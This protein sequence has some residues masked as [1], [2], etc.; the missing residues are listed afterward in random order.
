MLSSLGLSDGLT[1]ICS[2]FLKNFGG[3]V[4]L[5]WCAGSL[6]VEQGLSC[7]TARG[8]LVPQPG[9]GPT[10]LALEGEFFFLISIGYFIFAKIGP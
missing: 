2:S 7:P 10:S 1:L 6:V 3:T 5:L 9:V 8:I 4:S